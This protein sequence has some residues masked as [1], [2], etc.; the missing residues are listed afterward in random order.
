MTKTCTY[1]KEEK[2]LNLFG[3]TIRKDG[4]NRGTSRC[5]KCINYIV[6]IYSKKNIEK[7]IIN[8]RRFYSKNKDKSIAY[9]KN[10]YRAKKDGMYYVYLL[11]E[12]HYCGQTDSLYYRKA[13]HKSEGRYVEDMEAVISFKTRREAKQLE[14]AFHKLGWYGENELHSGNYK[15]A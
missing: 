6:S 12:E 4:S 14:K 9:T 10:Y 15:Y 3:K 2:D 1:C 5:K 8:Q 7:R 11:I 13:S